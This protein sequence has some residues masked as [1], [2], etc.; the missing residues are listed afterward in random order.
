M[1]KLPPIGTLLELKRRRFPQAAYNHG[2]LW[3]VT[4]YNTAGFFDTHP[5]NCKSLTTGK[6]YSFHPSHFKEIADA[7]D[8]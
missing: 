6:K 4:E 5:L 8:A 2:T 3:V 7:D 1:D